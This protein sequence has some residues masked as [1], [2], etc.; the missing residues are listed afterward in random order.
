MA[1]GGGISM[2]CAGSGSSLVTSR[3][4]L[5]PDAAATDSAVGLVS[6]GSCNTADGFSDTSCGWVDDF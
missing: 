2:S 4:N 5:P 6:A 1:M 3:P